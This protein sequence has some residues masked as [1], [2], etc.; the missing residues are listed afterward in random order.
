[1]SF[2]IEP[3]TQAI[4]RLLAAEPGGRIR[5]PDEGAAIAGRL[6]PGQSGVDPDTY[7]TLARYRESRAIRVSRS[8][9]AA[10]LAC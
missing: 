9:G 10:R 7:P 3:L 4:R 1:M 6:S 8:V 5:T 2:A